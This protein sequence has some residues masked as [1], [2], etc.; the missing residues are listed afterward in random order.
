MPG[1][2]VHRMKIIG[3]EDAEYGQ[4]NHRDW[5]S[6]PGAPR[7]TAAHGKDRTDQSHQAAIPCPD[8]E[9]G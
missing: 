3:D 6:I 4:N 1:C 5:R 2:H 8:R 9:P 7:F